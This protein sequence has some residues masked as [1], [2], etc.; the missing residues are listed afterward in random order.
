MESH[1]FKDFFECLAA[2]KAEI[3]KHQFDFA[4]VGAG[5][6]SLLLLKFIKDMGVPCVHL[7]GQTQLLF[8]IRGKRWET[9][10]TEESFDSQGFFH[11]GDLGF[12]KD[13]ELFVTGRLKEVILI[14]GRNNY[15]QDIELTVQNSHPALRPSCGAAFTVEGKGEERLVVVQEVERTW[16]RKIDID[17]VKRAIRKAV[18][19]EYDLQVYAIALIRTGSLPKTSSGKIQRRSCRA[20]FLEG[21]LEIVGQENS[22]TGT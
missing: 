12:I 16:L 1:P 2:I 13:G 6:Y 20:K 9:E 17:E 15:P 3:A 21:S 18:V 5:A 11:T 7:G 19:Q 22:S 4:V 14:R 8:G 10:Y